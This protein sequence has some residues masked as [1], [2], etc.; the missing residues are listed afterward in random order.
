MIET[1]IQDNKLFII[2]CMKYPDYVMKIIASCMTLDELDCTKK[3][4]DFIESSGTKETKRFKY[5]NPF[6]IHLRYRYQVDYQNNR[7]HAPT[8]LERIWATKL[9]TDYNFDW[10]LAASEVNT[11]LESGHFQNDGVVQPSL[12]FGELW[13]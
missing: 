9:W 13:K 8:S 1:K 10:Y 3:R 2:L 6:G 11:Y 4:R 7:R 12:Y 5:Q